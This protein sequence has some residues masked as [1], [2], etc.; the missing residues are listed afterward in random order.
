MHFAVEAIILL[1]SV[2]I[3]GC[4][5][6]VQVP[7][8]S[9][10]SPRPSSEVSTPPSQERHPPT[11][12]PESTDSS[13][14][15]EVAPALV[16]HTL[17]LVPGQYP[18]TVSSDG[19][20]IRTLSGDRLG[21]LAEGSFTGP[22]LSPDTSQVAFGLETAEF[23]FL[24]LTSGAVSVFQPYDMLRFN[25]SWSPEGR[26]L[27]VNGAEG[28]GGV[29]PHIGIIELDSLTYTRVTFWP[30][31]EYL[32][33]WSPDGAW[34]AFHS[35][36]G[37]DTLDWDLYLLPAN[38]IDTPQ[39]C[40]NRI[41]GPVPSDGSISSS[42]ASWSP[43]GRRV[44]AACGNYAGEDGRED[45]C[46]IEVESGVSRFITET[47]EYETAP[48]WSPDGQWIAFNRGDRSVVLI[49]PDDLGE[50]LIAEGE[51]FA[52]WMTVR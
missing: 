52:F 47:G 5:Q 8:V 21:L 50:R 12:T 29:I 7:T 36:H 42:G 25:P 33:A 51:S 6:T 14:Q 22:E 4:A 24:D 3:G 20:V 16:V 9:A 11:G 46:I 31:G 41:R 32:P 28:N 13:S 34:I 23:G 43:D 1:L 49:A 30:E 37:R 15:A 48:S 44:V 17:D 19:L 35:S 39:S 27:A 2:A 10:A 45:L 18:V 40:E 38:C 26:L